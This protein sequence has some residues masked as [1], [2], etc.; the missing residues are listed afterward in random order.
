[1]KKIQVL[2]AIALE[3]EQFKCFITK[4]SSEVKQTAYQFLSSARE[5]TPDSK[6]AA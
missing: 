2:E 6:S 5:L 1:M 3:S 4:V